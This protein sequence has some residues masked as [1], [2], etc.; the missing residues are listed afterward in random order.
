MAQIDVDAEKC[1]DCFKC[2]DICPFGVFEVKEKKV[3]VAHPKQCHLCLACEA[4]CPVHA[5]KI[6]ET[7]VLTGETR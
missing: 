5:I 4:E 3:S 6:A 7:A 1:N 2:V